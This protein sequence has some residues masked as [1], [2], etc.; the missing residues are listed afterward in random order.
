[1]T[2]PVG[3]LIIEGIRFQEDFT[4]VASPRL[5]VGWAEGSATSMRE[6]RAWRNWQTR[7]V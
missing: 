3:W 4:W 6:T 1:M 2:I 5:V 7:Q